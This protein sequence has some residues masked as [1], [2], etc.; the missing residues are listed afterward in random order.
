MKGNKGIQNTKII[1][2]S[3]AQGYEGEM[4]AYM[5]SRTGP[6]LELRE[7]AQPK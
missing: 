6:F 5:E 1:D 4:Q 2:G 3:G 7:V